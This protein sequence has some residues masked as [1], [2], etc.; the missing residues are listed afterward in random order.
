MEHKGLVSHNRSLINVGN[1]LLRAE[2][3][4]SG[5][6]Y[7]ENKIHTLELKL[8]EWPALWGPVAMGCAGMSLETKREPCSSGCRPLAPYSGP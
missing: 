3:Q 7:L 2:Q 5:R 6:L 1:L 4:D 8:G